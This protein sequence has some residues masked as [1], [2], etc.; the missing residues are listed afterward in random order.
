MR[1]AVLLMMT[2]GCWAAWGAD[3]AALLTGA[4][5]EKAAAAQAL[6]Y[7]KDGRA[8]GALAKAALDSDPVVAYAAAEA[9]GAIGT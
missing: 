3:T 6:G 2:V 9:L 1:S 7:A 4:P 5:Q 8:V